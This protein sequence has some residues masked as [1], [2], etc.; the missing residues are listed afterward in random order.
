MIGN[1]GVQ[2]ISIVANNFFPFRSFDESWKIVGDQSNGV[3]PEMFSPDKVSGFQNVDDIIQG[4]TIGQLQ[5]AEIDQPFDV[6][7]IANE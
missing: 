3:A 1:D 6:V 2:Q 7:L 4:Q 5:L